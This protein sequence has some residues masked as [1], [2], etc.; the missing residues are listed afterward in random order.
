MYCSH[1]G[2]HRPPFNNTPDPTFYFSTPEHEEALAT[3]QYI[4]FQRKGFVLVT[5]EVGAGKTLIGRM[6]LRQVDRSASV[7]VISHTNLTGRQL[8]AAIC[9]EFELDTPP[10]ATNLQLT[11]RLQNYLLEQFAQDRFAV[12]LLDE[13]QNL[14]DESFEELRMLGNLEADDAKL[15]QICILGQPELRERFHNPRL[16]QIDQRLFRR[17]HLPALSRANTEAYIGHRLRV[18]GCDRADLFT[19]EAIDR[20]YAASQGVPRLINKICDNG[21]LTAYGANADQVTAAMID[22]SVEQEIPPATGV[23]D[24]ASTAAR[25]ASASPPRARASTS[26]VA[27]GS[28][29]GTP[30]ATQPPARDPALEEAV[31][32]AAEAADHVASRQAEVERELNR[33]AKRITET[34]RTVREEMDRQRREIQGSLDEAVRQ[35][36]TLQ[37]RLGEQAAG[38]ASQDEVRRIRLAHQAEIDRLMLEMN[39]QGQEFRKLLDEAEKRWRETRSRMAHT[40]FDETAFEAI[41]SLRAESEEKA[42]DLL[43]RLDR[44]RQ[45]ISQLADILQGHCTQTQSELQA[46]RDAQ[47]AI[48]TRLSET[49]SELGA[50]ME[51]GKALSARMDGHEERIS[52]LDREIGKQLS[53]VV[54]TIGELEKRALTAADLERI[55]SDQTAAVGEVLSLIG[56][57][58]DELARFRQEITQRCDK[59]SGEA[60]ELISQ[61]DRRIAAQ[62]GY[63][64]A[65]REKVSEFFGSVDRRFAEMAERF[66]DR[67][68][69]N[70][71]RAGHEAAQLRQEAGL[72]EVRQLLNTRIEQHENRVAALDREIA[73]R[74]A[75]MTETIGELG[76]KALTSGDLVQ[77]RSEQAVAMGEVLKRIETQGDELAGFR[78]EIT[79]RYAQD[80]EQVQTLV[81]EID[82]RIVAQAAQVEAM[83]A[84]ASE[85]VDS[86]ERRLGE[87]PERFAD[88]AGSEAALAE[89]RR[90]HETHAA[91]VLRRIETNRDTM[92]R[93]VGNVVE[94]FRATEQHLN[95]LAATSAGR[96]EVN[97]L[98]SRQE[99]ET[100]SLVERLEAQKLAMEAQFD[101]VL[102]RLQ[103]TQGQID[104]LS[105]DAARTSDFEQFRRQHEE[106]QERVLTVLSVQRRDLESLADTTRGRCDEM[107][108]RLSAIPADVATTDQVEQV[109]REYSAQV[110]NVLNELETRRGQLEQSIRDVAEYCDRTNSAVSALAAEAATAEE[111]AALRNEHSRKLEEINRQITEKETVQVNRMHVLTCKVKDN[112]QR[113]SRIEEER[114]RPVRLELAPTAGKDLGKL[115]EAA[116]EQHGCLS[117]AVDRAGAI[118]SHIHNVSAHVQEVMHYWA[119]N[120]DKVQT[121]SRQL[122]ESAETAARIL[123][124]MQKCHTALDRKLNSQRWQHELARGEAVVQKLEKAA[125]RGQDV[126]RQLAA[127]LRD[128]ERTQ[129]SAEEFASRTKQTQQTVQ[130]MTQQARQVV[131]QLSKLLG[132]ASSVST[133]FDQNLNRRKQVLTA[134][135]QN[136]ARLM[137]LIETARQADE[138]SPGPT[139]RADGLAAKQPGRRAET[140]KPEKAA[141]IISQIEWPTVR[142][143]PAQVG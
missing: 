27:R 75:A 104:T 99:Q 48:E 50:L 143:R 112:A 98:R 3:L 4:V 7:A 87:L 28:D 117:E 116:G 43:A 29:V 130:E 13:A 76:S 39:Q 132:E 101:R 64:D 138:A 26:Q 77:I 84:K 135:A 127:I 55:R 92:K 11:E 114:S 137:D 72:A 25:D 70:V 41:E 8:L 31:R 22:Q 93:L 106:D 10:D 60:G 49:G 12:V 32:S 128:F 19:K 57:Q 131:N 142:A 1:F 61:I 134:V 118:A 91:E 63:L 33:V 24:N 78:R 42:Q 90:T 68:E 46:L 83:R 100:R 52:L 82:Q 97:E 85:F 113:V 103:E 62:A 88:R 110:R 51:N 96:D 15:L 66:A 123:A 122:R 17:F 54:H 9:H 126:A 56:R 102:W 2:L 94:R 139:G 81:R 129:D 69:L 105:S 119:D 59:E 111:V 34:W 16:R 14:P 23:A 35:Y 80:S 86:I 47:V 115:V 108:A 67:T 73:Q 20:I 6:F 40:G 30:I 44:H 125:A 37:A 124:A 5:G 38:A 109:R 21:L 89:L 95:T 79:T 36:Q 136:T 133:K 65:L 53:A 120:A 140:R 71:I 107:S 141:R 74:L 58:S 45:H 121:Q 18:A